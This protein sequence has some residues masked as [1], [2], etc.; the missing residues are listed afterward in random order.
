[1]EYVYIIYYMVKT[2]RLDDGI[3]K[4]R[5]IVQ[6]EIQM[7]TGEVTSM[8]DVIDFLLTTYDINKK[9]RKK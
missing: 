2:I 3:H 8:S 5:I 9:K 7:E 1:M 4:E 6:G